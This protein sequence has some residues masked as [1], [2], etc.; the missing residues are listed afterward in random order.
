MI[1]ANFGRTK[2]NESKQR[3][4]IAEYVELCG[5]KNGG[6]RKSECQNDTLKLSLDEIASQLGISRKTLNRALSIE[7]NLTDS[8]KELLDTGAIT[9]TLA[10]DVIATLSKEEQ[11]KLIESMDATKQ[12][13]KKEVQKYIDKI[14]KLENTPKINS[15]DITALDNIKQQ[16]QNKE[17]ELQ[18][19]KNDYRA[20][21][22]NYQNKDRE[23]NQLKEKIKKEEENSPSGSTTG[24]QRKFIKNLC[25]MSF[26]GI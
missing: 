8:M 3:K 14:K 12:I 6:D 5:Y 10:S 21:Y 15:V 17:Q 24:Q 1:A 18:N 16:L 2:N 13:T 23:L 9:K 7:R 11:E 19:S 4:A 20:L 26:G 25:Y 22:S